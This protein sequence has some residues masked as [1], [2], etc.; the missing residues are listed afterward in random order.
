M[1]VEDIKQFLPQIPTQS[2]VYQFFD[3]DHQILYV[4]KA[5]NLAKRVINYTNFAGLSLRIKRMVTLAKSIEINLTNTEL[6]ALLLEHNLIKKLLPPFNILLKDG[7]TFSQIAISKHIFPQIHKYRGKKTAENQKIFGPFADAYAVKKTIDLIRKT[8][9]LR[10]CND[11]EF[12][13]RKKP[14]LDYQIKK[15]SAPCVG[16]IKSADYSKNVVS[17]IAVLSGKTEQVKADLQQ[18]MQQHSH[19]LQYE[20]AIEIRDQI[21]AIEVISQKQSINTFFTGDFDLLNILVLQS[22]ICVYISFYRAGQNYGAKPYFFNYEEDINLS[23]FMSDFL[24]DFIG[25]FYLDNPPPSALICNVKPS[26]CQLLESFLTNL[27]NKKIVIENPKKGVKFNLLQEQYHLGW[28]LL[29]QKISHNLSTKKILLEMKK[30]FSLAKVPQ[31][32]EVYDN[33]HTNFTN[34]VGAMITTGV[35][36]FIKSA[37]RKFYLQQNNSKEVVNITNN[38]QDDTAMLKE[39]LYRRF[40]NKNNKHQASMPDLLLIDGGKLQVDA[41]KTILQELN[42]DIAIIGIA[43]GE[44]RNAGKETFHLPNQLE[45]KLEQHSPVLY[46]L[47]KIRDEAHRF[48]ISSHRILRQKKFITK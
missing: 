6:E 2:G 39:M 31:R 42:L 23:D 1:S 8:F 21:K 9:L 25:Q 24:S 19:N 5:K 12:N 32:I 28:Q 43:K 48:A 40:A 46:F 14:C 3:K 4:G 27:A 13:N 47:Q 26:N 22:K 29:E 15:C 38:N 10:G 18:K 44:N 7:K 41:V 16:L 37:Y 11:T 33:S 17:A 20:K 36:G 35:D 30:I 34:A 45:I